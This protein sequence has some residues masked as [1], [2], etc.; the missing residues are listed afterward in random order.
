MLL[1]ALLASLAAR[2]FRRGEA[3][4]WIAVAPT[5]ITCI[6]LTL[7]SR[8]VLVHWDGVD[9]AV[10]GLLLGTGYG[11][12]AGALAWA[13]RS[14]RNGP[15][16]LRFACLTHLSALMLVPA[17]AVLDRPLDVQPVDW[18]KTALVLAGVGAL[19]AGSYFWHRYRRR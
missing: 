4:N 13:L 10:V 15:A 12:V 7:L 17:S 8:T 19:V 11:L 1:H 6:G 16:A 18:E 2:R 14:R 5:P 3:A 9:G